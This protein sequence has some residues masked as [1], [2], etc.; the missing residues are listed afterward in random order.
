[1]AENK[2]NLLYYVQH[3]DDRKHGVKFDKDKVSYRGHTF[4]AVLSKEFRAH[5][6]KI[7]QEKGLSLPLIIE[8]QASPSKKHYFTKPKP[9][10]YTDKQT[11]VVTRKKKTI[12]TL[13]KCDS[14][15][16]GEFSNQ[17]LDDIVDDIDGVDE[18][19]V[20]E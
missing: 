16:Q 4:D 7:I 13:L 14:I 8:V 2:M 3:V 15:T 1:M 10:D 19:E 18:E 12:I 11:G 17:S 5:V 9:Y 6:E 20:E